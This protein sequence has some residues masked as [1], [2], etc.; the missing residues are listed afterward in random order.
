MRSPLTGEHCRA[1]ARDFA[2]RP[3]T[4]RGPTVAEFCEDVA[5][6]DPDAIR[7]VTRWQTAIHRLGH[8]PAPAAG[9]V[10]RHRRARRGRPVRQRGSRR[11]GSRGDPDSDEGDPEPV[12]ARSQRYRQTRQGATPASDI[13]VTPGSSAIDGTCARLSLT[14]PVLVIDADGVELREPEISDAPIDVEPVLKI[15]ADGVELREVGS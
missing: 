8:R 11:G 1:A 13:D 2:A 5:A 10:G 7:T 12:A 3:R 14:D 9:I 15:T 4:E 6:G